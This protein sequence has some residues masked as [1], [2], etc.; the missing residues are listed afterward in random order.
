MS[1]ERIV[2]LLYVHNVSGNRPLG[3]HSADLFQSSNRLGC[4]KGP[5]VL[6]I[7]NNTEHE[8]AITSEH[9]NS[10]P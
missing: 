10:Y 3:S 6:P 9:T 5:K 8:I 7:Y 4:G 1:A 2:C